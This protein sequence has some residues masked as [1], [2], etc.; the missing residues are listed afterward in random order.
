MKCGELNRQRDVIF[1]DSY[2]P[3]E[4]EELVEQT[5]NNYREFKVGYYWEEGNILKIF[6]APHEQ[7][8]EELTDEFIDEQ[9]DYL[10]SLV[11]S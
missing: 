2:L 11:R 8:A 5:L 3:S 6:F 1:P 10:R 4:A 7:Y 9:I